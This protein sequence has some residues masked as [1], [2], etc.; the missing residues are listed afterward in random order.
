MADPYD[1]LGD[2]GSGDAGETSGDGGSESWGD[3]G[4][5]NGNDDNQKW[6]P[7]DDEV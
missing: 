4:W 2:G 7:D 3:D 5:G 1:F 6:S